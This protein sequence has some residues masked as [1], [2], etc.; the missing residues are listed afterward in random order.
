MEPKA[1]ENT[2]VSLNGT[3]PNGTADLSCDPGLAWSDGSTVHTITCQSH[4]VWEDVKLHCVSEWV[5]AGLDTLYIYIYI[6]K[7][8]QLINISLFS[9]DYIGLRGMPSMNTFPNQ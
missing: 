8:A 2:T 1:V 5:V 6:S 3:T 9:Q 7:S 4:G